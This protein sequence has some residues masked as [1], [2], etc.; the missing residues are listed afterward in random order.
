MEA[1]YLDNAATTPLSPLVREAMEPWLGGEWGNPSSVHRR[2]VRAREAIDRARTQVARAVGAS[3]EGVIFTSGGT[4]ANNLALFGLLPP[5]R[6]RSGGL[7]VGPT[8]HASVRAA[9]GA[10]AED[11]V[12]VTTASLGADGRLDLEELG[13]RLEQQPVLVAQMLVSNE[14]GSVY[15]LAEL[16]RMIRA[17]TA[18][19]TLLHVDAVQAL[20]K[21]ELSMASIGADSLSL[22]AHK[23]HGPQGVGA[24][25]LSRELP[26]LRPLIHGGGQEEGKR[27]GTENVAG[28]VGFGCAA[29]LADLELG[30]TA[31]HLARL[32]ARLIEG[33][34]PL[35]GIRLLIPGG[36]AAPHQPGIVSLTV[37]GA[38]AE[39]WLHH[40]DA[41]GVA[42][43]TGSACQARKR[44]I[45]PVLSAA[46]LSPEQARGVLRLSFSRENTLEELDRVV[47]LLR[48][49]H[50]EL[51]E[52]RR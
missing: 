41:R 16:S 50:G 28:I 18:N 3:P 20:G 47:V 10:L 11:G 36:E 44:E 4:E 37:P 19:R 26:P 23:I 40:L 39:V 43:G 35:E 33:I 8:E 27:S 21:L 34:D 32:R 14:F 9:A 46:G 29:E 17:R 13:E 7:L 6:E 1:I 45:S 49:V 15:P 5:R 30:A 22:S 12:A 38:A 25:V 51:A 52:L 42:V 48:E 31:A 24:L 2:G